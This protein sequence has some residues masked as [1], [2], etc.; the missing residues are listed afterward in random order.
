MLHCL[1][2]SG[3]GLAMNPSTYATFLMAS[4]LLDSVVSVQFTG[5]RYQPSSFS[6]E[7]RDAGGAF[8][9]LAT[10]EDMQQVFKLGCCKLLAADTS[11]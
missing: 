6:R 9:R 3:S 4:L 5:C 7:C 1:A 11:Q 2:S 8:A 10:L